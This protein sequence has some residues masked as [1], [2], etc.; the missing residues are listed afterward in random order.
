MEER[1]LISLRT[2]IRTE[3]AWEIVI[4]GAIILQRSE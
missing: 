2:V 1:R 3:A 4:N